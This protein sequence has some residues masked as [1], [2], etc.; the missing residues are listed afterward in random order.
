MY[1]YINICIVLYAA[2]RKCLCFSESTENRADCF[3][4]PHCLCVYSLDDGVSQ[5]R[6]LFFF[7]LFVS[8]LV[9]SI[10][11]L[12]TASNVFSLLNQPLTTLTFS[13]SKSFMLRCVST[14]KALT[15]PGHITNCIACSEC[16]M[17]GSLKEQAEIH[18]CTCQ[19][20][21]PL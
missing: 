10:L 12:F 21:L 6:F 15:R 9:S 16:I 11:L 4:Y 2:A 3:Q 20:G 7:F 14:L 19:L 1:V 17:Y 8:L 5:F 18:H 13:T